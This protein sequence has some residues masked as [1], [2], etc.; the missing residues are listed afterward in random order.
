MLAADL[1]HAF[2]GDWVKGFL[3][4][5]STK[6]MT[7][8]FFYR[9]HR[10]HTLSDIKIEAYYFTSA[11]YCIV[12]QQAKDKRYVGTFSG[13]KAKQVEFVSQVQ[14]IYYDASYSINDAFIF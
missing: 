14:V 9:T 2:V 10:C 12:C 11:N 7:F 4:K 1:S 6:A 3:E 8:F 5:D 13:A